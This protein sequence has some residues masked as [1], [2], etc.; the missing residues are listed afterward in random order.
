MEKDQEPAEDWE[1]PQEMK[2]EAKEV[3]PKSKDAVREKDK[4]RDKEE[5]DN[6]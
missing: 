2:W 1:N 4:N 3:K 6:F 5:I